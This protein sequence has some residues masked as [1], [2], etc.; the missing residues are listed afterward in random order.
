MDRPSLTQF[1]DER[2]SLAEIGRRVGLH[3]A[4]VG[5]WVKKYG[6]EAANREKHAAQGG[7]PR[8]E[9]EGLVNAGMSTSQIAEAVGLSKTTVRHWLQEFGLSTHW[10]R[11]RQ[12]SAGREPDLLAE[13][14]LRGMTTFRRRS[15]GGYRCVRCRAEAVSRRRR[16]VKQLLVDEAGG[17]CCV[18][19]Y[20]RCVAALEFHHVAPAEK[21]FSLSHRGVTRSLARARAEASKCALVCANCHAQVEA[22]MTTLT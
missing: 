19:G 13:C 21:S 7:V 22:G 20:S 17:A 18:C 8:Q 11:R 15:E 9:L 1:L 5:Y 6:L 12:A 4:T 10:A 16:K 14:S 2:L 3:E